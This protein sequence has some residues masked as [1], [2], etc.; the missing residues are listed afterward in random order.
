MASQWMI[1]YEPDSGNEIW[2]VHHGKGDQA[3]RML[4]GRIQHISITR[5]AKPRV[6]EGEAKA[7][8]DAT[9]EP[10]TASEEDAGKK[11]AESTSPETPAE[12]SK[13]AAEDGDGD[14]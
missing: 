1:A 8:S 4:P 2:R 14:K 12:D 5:S 13:P 10:A 11:S 7:G 6:G 3:I 9:P